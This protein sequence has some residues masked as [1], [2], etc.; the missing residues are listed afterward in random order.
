[1]CFVEFYYYYYLLGVT[2]HSTIDNNDG[3]QETMT[4]S[5][6]THD[7][8]KTIFQVLSIQEKENI[9]V[10]GEVERPLL[11]RDEPNI[12]TTEPLPYSIG[13]RRGPELFTQFQ[14]QYDVDQIQITLKRDIAWSLCGVLNDDELPMLGSWTCFNKFVSDVNYE[15]V[16]QKYLPVNPHPPEY[17]ICKEYLDFL[18]EVIDE[19]EIPFIFVHSDEMVYSKLC[20][21]LWQNKDI[22]NQ[23]ILLMGGFHQLRVMQRLLYKRH[24][25]KG[26]REWC[27]DAKTI[28]EGSVDQA[29][30]GRHYYRSMRMHKECFD[31]LVQFR[32][33][34]ITG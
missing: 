20:E 32:I 14:M 13:K 28:A 33:E 10:I 15:A 18:L 30:E 3:R 21:I 26:Y 2:T 4:G 9:P 23:I 12:W 24:F 25:T 11:L 7:T 6:T 16:V 5:G 1:M 17:P 34:K 22:Y 8:N 27:V 29:F 31:A 19:L